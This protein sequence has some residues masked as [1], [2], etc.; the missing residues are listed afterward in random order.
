MKACAAFKEDPYITHDFGEPK[1]QCAHCGFNQSEHGFQLDE[2]EKN[3]LQTFLRHI[4]TDPENA[5]S[6]VVVWLGDQEN[7]K[8][9]IDKG[10]RY[11]VDTMAQEGIDVYKPNENP[12]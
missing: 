10:W 6:R 1:G 5:Y 7:P 3:H 4:S 8:Y 12:I 11:V 2:F 9:C